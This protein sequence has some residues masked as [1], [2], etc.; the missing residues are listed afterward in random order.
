MEQPALA[1]MAQASPAHLGLAAQ[2]WSWGLARRQ[3]ST[4]PVETCP[5]SFAAAKLSAPAAAAIQRCLLGGSGWGR[6]GGCFPA[7][8]VEALPG[9]ARD[10]TSLPVIACPGICSYVL[11]AV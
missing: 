7:V 5:R 1:R 6:V 3:D 10:N 11:R 9:H 8:M 2:P 4:L